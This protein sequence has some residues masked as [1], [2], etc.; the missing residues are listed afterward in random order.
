MTVTVFSWKN[1]QKR[2]IS[3]LKYRILAKKKS[4]GMAHAKNDE[5]R[6]TRM[7]KENGE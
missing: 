7:E 3:K 4:A 1:S 2:A 5:N 6:L